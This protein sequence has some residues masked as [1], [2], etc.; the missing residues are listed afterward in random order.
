MKEPT[1]RCFVQT[2][3]SHPFQK[4]TKTSFIALSSKLRMI[5][6]LH[7]QAGSS[8]FAPWQEFGDEG[9]PDLRDAM[10]LMDRLVG[11]LCDGA[12]L[13]MVAWAFSRWHLN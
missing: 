3:F 5:T 8:A 1:E 2:G 11:R 12:K 4:T 6:E 13:G 10:L 9:A 7:S